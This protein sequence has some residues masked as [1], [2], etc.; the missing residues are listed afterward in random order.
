[1]NRMEI[2]RNQFI[3]TRNMCLTL[4][5]L[6]YSIVIGDYG[7]GYLFS[8]MGVFLFL[9][10][11]TVYSLPETIAKTIRFRIQKGKNKNVKSLLRIFMWCGVIYSVF[12]CL[13]LLGSR[14]LLERIFAPIPCVGFALLLLIPG[15]ILYVFSQIFRGYFQ[16]MGSSFPTGFSQMLGAIIWIL[17]GSCL[18]IYFYY[19]GKMVAD[20]LHNEQVIFAY[21]LIG[22]VLG[23]D[24]SMVVVFAFLLFLYFVN[25]RN[26]S[27]KIN[28]RDS[29][30]N[31]EQLKFDWSL[32]FKSFIPDL[33]LNGIS[34]ILFI[35][36][37]FVF[38]YRYST[39][40]NSLDGF[41]FVGAYYGKFLLL[42]LLFTFVI[43]SFIIPLQYRV[44]HLFHKEQYIIGRE[45]FHSGI[46]F[47][48][49]VGLFFTVVLGVL[50]ENFF[51]SFHMIF[52]QFQV[53]FSF[54]S[55]L[56]LLISITTYIQNVLFGLGYRKKVIMNNLVS[57]FC[58]MIYF[59]IIS[60]QFKL[61]IALFASSFLIYYF[62]LL[63]ISGFY[64]FRFLRLK[65]NIR[66][67]F[68]YPMLSSLLIG[69]IVF[70]LN[71]ALFSLIGYFLSF[72][73]CVIVGIVG[74]LIL[75]FAFHCID[76]KEIV[77]FSGGKFILKIGEMLKLL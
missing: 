68:L 10:I 13:F 2:N 43:N 9:I 20:L 71:K 14:L 30:K 39:V 63:V 3:N 31:A 12:G 33:L 24:I 64:C 15:Y 59:V 61:S 70:L 34:Y 23:F 69:V 18:V 41:A 4:G 76:R 21:P 54:G 47:I 74:Y 37:L 35:V 48:L 32:I 56:I 16:G 42:V 58:F 49:I 25:K 28:F 44:I 26:Q 7:A 1:M 72:V 45:L 38:Q 73:V 55:I 40:I 27:G 11:F 22:I 29:F 66:S 19:Y 52:K 6:I 17:F 46:H 65:I 5:L 36:G 60:N 53:L 75:L 77:V 8:F 62:I 67:L 57:L 51:K 50:G